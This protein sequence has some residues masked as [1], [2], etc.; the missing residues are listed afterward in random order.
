M[1]IQE[2]MNRIRLPEDA[3]KDVLKSLLNE[4]EYQEAKKLFYENN[5]KF[6]E[7]WKKIEQHLQWTLSFYLQLSCEV[8]EEYQNKGILDKVFDDTF[9]DITIWCEECHRKYGF[10]G[11]EEA[12]WVANSILMKLFRLGRL[13]FEPH[14]LTEVIE[15]E[16]VKLS[17]GS[18][19]LNV[20]IPAGEKMDY[21]ECMKS[22]KAAEE[23]FGDTYE[24][25]MCDSWLLSPVLKEFLPETS[26]IIRFQNLFHV[27]EVN[28][29][30]PQGEER[31]FKDVRIDKENYPENS[32]LQ[33][34]AKEYILSGKDL[35][36]GVGVFY[37][38][39]DNN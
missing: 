29:N 5:D 31:I 22:F 18:K 14:V 9:Y 20:H 26:N 24:A 19:V 2:L 30:F 13:Q 27:F 32:S 8:Y 1:K 39:Q 17:E 10:Y 23:F 12:Q 4:K 21:E 11:I 33:K 36:I 34:K 37:K 6:F 16:F 25:Y 38:Y 15:G 35:G 28:H 3:Q 7:E